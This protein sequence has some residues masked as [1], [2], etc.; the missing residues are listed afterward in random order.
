MESY[1]NRFTGSNIF[2][3]KTIK[4]K[5]ALIFLSLSIFLLNTAIHAADSTLIRLATT[6]ST[7]N[8]GLLNK[9]LPAFTLDSG[10][11]V[12]VIAVGTGKALRLGRDGDVDI[13]L[14]HALQAENEFV[15]SGYGVKRYPVMY[16]D[17]VVIGP[18][19]DPAKISSA[20]SVK[21][22]FKRISGSE[23]AF[24]SR[25]DN[26]GTHKKELSIWKQADIKPAGSWYREAGQGM[27][28]I[29]QMANEMDAYTL[30]DRGT[31]LAYQ[32]KV[33]LKINH[34]GDSS[35]FNPYGII[36]VNPQRYSDINFA[37]SNALINWITAKD[38][39]QPL[40]ADYKMLG[41]QLF[42]PMA[43]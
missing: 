20:K 9:I 8:S 10:Y 25:G 35:L 40:I 26:S 29:L 17:F 27:G 11:Q 4:M 22:A 23:S 36:A 37:G 43:D 3:Y 31:W 6:T 13:I 12:H 5:P 19:S 18:A 42:T 24:I 16:N 39:G 7:E 28:R 1:K 38:K 34:Q 41:K 33:Q 15:Q 30:T 32:S 14:V 21:Q 2:N